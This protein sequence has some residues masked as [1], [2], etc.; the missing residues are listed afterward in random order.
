MSKALPCVGDITTSFLEHIVVTSLEQKME[1]YCGG[2]NITTLENMV[3]A[4]PLD[5][6]PLSHYKWR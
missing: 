5:N 3:A 2:E 4:H 1:Q 6:F